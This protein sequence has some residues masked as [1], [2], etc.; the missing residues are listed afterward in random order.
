MA[1]SIYPVLDER[2][3]RQTVV[4]TL[5]MWVL[6]TWSSRK[7]QTIV[8]NSAALVVHWCLTRRSRATSTSGSGSA[9][10]ASCKEKK[11]VAMWSFI[12]LL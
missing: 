9:T 11:R 8:V 3:A 12:S 7:N 1:M 10:R 4:A 6:E 5:R 2:V